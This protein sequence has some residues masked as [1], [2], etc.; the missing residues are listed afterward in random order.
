MFRFL[1]I[2]V[3]AVLS[4]VGVSG[5]ARADLSL[6]VV[7]MQEILNK[8]D[9]AK[10]ILDQVK[11]QRE[12]LAKEIK[13]IETPLKNDEQALILK[14]DT[15]KPEE[16]MALKKAFEKK[17]QDARAKVQDKR[18]STD[19]AFNKAVAE[20]RDNVMAVVSGISTEKKIQLVITKQNVVI[21]DNNLDITADVM[22]KLNARVKT[23]KIKFN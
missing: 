10:S 13:D 12:K 1:M 3:V 14:K 22:T 7:D 9:A 15:A 4:V 16:F 8:S 2:A 11:V 20:L 19:E 21:G 5:V 23:I 6:A 17:L 18:K